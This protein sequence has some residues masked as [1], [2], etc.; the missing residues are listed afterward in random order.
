[1]KNRKIL[2][3]YSDYLIASFSLMT[4]SGLSDLL[5]GALSHD[6]ISRFLGQRTFSQMDYWKCVKLIVRRFEHPNGVI[7]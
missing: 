1:M 5:D 3:L 4:S 7:K 6:Q 2:D